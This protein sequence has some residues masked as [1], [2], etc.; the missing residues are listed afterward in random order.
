MA[1]RKVERTLYMEHIY[2]KI[3]HIL[4]DSDHFSLARS[5]F[6]GNSGRYIWK[7]RLGPGKW[8]KVTLTERHTEAGG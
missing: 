1:G 8:Y 5:F 4:G 6:L 7:V 2:E 3:W